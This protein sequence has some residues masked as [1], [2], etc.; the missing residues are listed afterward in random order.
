MERDG[1]TFKLRRLR[2]AFN[3]SIVAA[4]CIDDARS[5][6]ISC[7]VEPVSYCAGCFDRS[8]VIQDYPKF[9]D[10]KSRISTTHRI[11]PDSVVRLTSRIRIYNS[12]PRFINTCINESI[13]NEKVWEARCSSWNKRT[14]ESFILEYT[15]SPYTSYE[16]LWSV[17]GCP[18]SCETLPD[19]TTKAIEIIETRLTSHS[20]GD[21]NRPSNYVATLWTRYQSNDERFGLFNQ[22]FPLFFTREKKENHEI[23]ILWSLVEGEDGIKFLFETCNMEYKCRRAIVV[24]ETTLARHTLYDDN[25]TLVVRLW[26]ENRSEFIEP[27]WCTGANIDIRHTLRPRYLSTAVHARVHTLCRA[28]LLDNDAPVTPPKSQ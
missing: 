16:T 13:R 7:R 2:V 23:F 18:D 6:K 22:R 3:Q 1:G 8:S 12:A 19:W 4:W 27:R 24:G 20:L 21:R 26:R 11:I 5:E 9:D 14:V 25:S 28:T 17:H 10:I 15:S